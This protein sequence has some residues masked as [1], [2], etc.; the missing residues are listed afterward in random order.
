MLC[1]LALALHLLNH[2]PLATHSSLSLPSFCFKSL[3][4]HFSWLIIRLKEIQHWFWTLSQVTN[5]SSIS[6]IKPPQ[7]FV[8][9]KTCIRAN[10]LMCSKM[11]ALSFMMVPCTEQ[12]KH[13]VFAN[14]QWR[15]PFSCWLI[16]IL[17]AI[18]MVF[19]FLN[20]QP[21]RLPFFTWEVW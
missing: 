2:S 4:R 12:I 21:S 13:K 15:V 17:I 7:C 8:T 14:L 19:L 5:S 11:H 10:P 1:K 16:L 6:I 20:A 18:V 3:N 9:I